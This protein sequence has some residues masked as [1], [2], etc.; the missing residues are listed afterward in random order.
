MVFPLM[1]KSS[2]L[3][4]TFK[5]TEDVNSAFKALGLDDLLED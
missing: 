1:L 2:K 5:N 4:M 3:H